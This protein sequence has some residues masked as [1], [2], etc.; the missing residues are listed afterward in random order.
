[1]RTNIVID[2]QLVEEAMSLAGLH[3]KRELV[4]LALREFVA[5]R[6]RLNL[7]CLRGADLIDENYDY[8]GI[9]ERNMED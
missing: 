4:E 6:K 5:S 7:R 8:K 9:R 3:T 1:M 2:D